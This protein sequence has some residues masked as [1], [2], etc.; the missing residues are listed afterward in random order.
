MVVQPLHGPYR[1]LLNATGAQREQAHRDDEAWE[2]AAG[3]EVAADCEV[4][5][6]YRVNSQSRP[7]STRSICASLGVTW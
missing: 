7:A 3:H 1:Q 2:E 6:E 4:L 5:D